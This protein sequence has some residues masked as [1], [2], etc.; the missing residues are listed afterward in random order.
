MGPRVLK[1][2]R[3]ELEKIAALQFPPKK[4]TMSLSQRWSKM[5]GDPHVAEHAAHAYEF[6]T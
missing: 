3:E 2:F 6:M 5:K 4:P 1:A